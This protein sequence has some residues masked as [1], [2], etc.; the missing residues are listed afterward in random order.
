VR[1]FPVPQGIIRV[2][3]C[4]ESGLL[5]CPLCSGPELEEYFVT[6]TEPTEYC[7]PEHCPYCKPALW[8]PWLPWQDRLP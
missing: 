6:G 3:I 4:P 5:R 8:W 1:E 2:S 7:S